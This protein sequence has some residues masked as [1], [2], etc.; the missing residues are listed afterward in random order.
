M[1]TEF[2]LTPAKPDYRGMTVEIIGK[3]PESKPY[4]SVGYSDRA[5]GSLSGADLE[6]FAVNIPKALGSKKLKP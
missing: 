4:V 3:S 1:K 5:F 2:Y 6:R